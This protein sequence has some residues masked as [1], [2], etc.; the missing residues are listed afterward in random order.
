M[1]GMART[2]FRAVVIDGINWGMIST[3][4]HVI[5]NKWLAK[6]EPKQGGSMESVMHGIESDSGIYCR[7]AQM[8]ESSPIEM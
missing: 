1:E 4:T 5:K 3:G 7:R 6:G 8:P 2:M